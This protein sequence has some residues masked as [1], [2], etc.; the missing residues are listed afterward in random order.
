MRNVCFQKIGL[1]FLFT[2]I[3]ELM[4]VSFTIADN[5]TV[6]LEAS[7]YEIM[8]VCDKQHLIHMEDFGTFLVPGNPN[9]PGKIFLVLLPPGAEVIS[10][11]I[12]K[13][14][15]DSLPGEYRILPVYPMVPANRDQEIMKRCEKEWEDNY[16]NTYSFDRLYPKEICQYR[17]TGAFREYTFA[18]ISYIPFSYRPISGKLY[19]HRSVIISIDYILPGDK[20]KGRWDTNRLLSDFWEIEKASRLFYNYEQARR[21]YENGD[22][23]RSQHT[24]ESPFYDYVIITTDALQ[25]AVSSLVTWK[26]SIGHSVNVVTISW[27]ISNYSGSDLEETIRNFL[28]DKY[29]SVEWGIRYVLIVGDISD[30]PMRH[31]FPDPT[32]HNIYSQYAPPTDYYYA[33]LTGNWDS[34]GDGYFGEYGQDNVDFVPEV[35]VGRIPWSDFSTVTDICQKIVAFESDTGPWKNTALLLAAISNFA[36]EDNS[37]WPKTDG[38]YL[39]EEMISH[40]LSGWSYTT[41]YEKSGLNSSIFSCDFPLDQTNVVNNWSS[42]NYGI[43]NWSAHGSAINAWRKWWGFDDNDGI[44]E[45]SEMSWLPFFNITDASLLDDAHPSIVFASSCD[46]GKPEGDNLGK[47]LIKSGSAGAVASTRISWY[48][49]G[50]TNESWGGNNSMDYHFFRYLIL[51]GEKVGDALFDSKVYYSTHYFGMWPASQQWCHWAN[52]FDFCL[53]GEP[54]LIREGTGSTVYDISGILTYYSSGVPIENASVELTGGNTLSTTTDPTGSYQFQDVQGGLDYTLT[55]SKDDDLKNAISGSDAL[56]ILRHLAFVE[57]LSPD[58][59]IAADVCPDGNVTGADA[60]AVLRYL[61]FFTTDICDVGNW[62][63]RPESI[64]IAS[65]N[66]NMTDQ[67]F[68]AYLLGDPT[69]DW[70][71]SFASLNMGSGTEKISLQNLTPWGEDEEERSHPTLIIGKTTSIN[72]GLVSIPVT[73][74]PEDVNVHTLE[75]TVQYDPS[76]LKYEHTRTTDLTDKFLLVANGQNN[77]FVHVAMAGVHGVEKSGSIAKIVFRRAVRAISNEDLEKLIITR[78]VINDENPTVNEEISTIN[79][80]TRP[81]NTAPCCDI[82]LHNYPNPFNTETKIIFGLQENSYVKLSIFNLSGQPVR[83]LVDGS[84]FAGFHEIHWNGK[85]NAGGRVASG[86]YFFTLSTNKQYLVK[87]MILLK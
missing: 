48:A 40:L 45:S 20:L 18:K 83:T 33:D 70:G 27:I 31:C 50:W 3:L 72:D 39:M 85:D 58:Q 24:N 23:V 69:G 71:E 78:I 54:S 12:E 47:Q 68:R 82:I 74:N 64:E 51:N 16:K 8:E 28:R 36:N 80:N 63:F 26:Q 35:I 43:V 87:K 15:S 76:R 13:T 10:V 84:I 73:L 7:P 81:L 65:L 22:D 41:M 86:I 21:F 29:P 44:P 75:F 59:I 38:A 77:G 9:L 79:R 4:C 67:N 1:Y 5:L 2:L 25:S 52:M 34:D 57:T 14:F 56:S 42:N 55:P 11:S 60:L 62:I 19:Y 30:I 61:A 37:G 66:Q 53:F 46:N 49:I 17:G 6:Q 32:D